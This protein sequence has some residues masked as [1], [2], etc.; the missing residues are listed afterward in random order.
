[1]GRNSSERHS[2][3]F[4]LLGS[5]PERLLAPPGSV[6]VDVCKLTLQKVELAHEARGGLVGHLAQPAQPQQL[7][8]LRAQPQ[9]A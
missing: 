2:E 8:A 4:R 7:F 1:V 9:E 3:R 6:H 5:P